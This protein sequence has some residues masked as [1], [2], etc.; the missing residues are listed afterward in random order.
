[1]QNQKN[2]QEFQD[3]EMIRGN[4]KLVWEHLGEGQ[5][6]DYDPTDPTDQPLLRF[7]IFWRENESAEWEELGDSSYCTGLVTNTPETKLKAYGEKILESLPTTQ[8][9]PIGYRRRLQ[10]WSW[11][12]ITKED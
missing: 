9:K 11:L 6:G 7:S 2:Y 5:E 4:I 10:A 8:D 1:M 3:L 12:G